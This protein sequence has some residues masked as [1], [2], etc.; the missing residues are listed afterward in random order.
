M[1]T[2]WHLVIQRRRLMRLDGI[3]GWRA[4]L[5]AVGAFAVSTS[6]VLAIGWLLA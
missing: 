2:V 5:W 4:S 1:T 6:V 3:I